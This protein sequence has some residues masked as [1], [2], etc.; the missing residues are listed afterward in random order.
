MTLEGTRAD[1]PAEGENRSL[2]LSCGHGAKAER[3]AEQAIAALLQTDTVVDAAK[4]TGISE[5]TLERWMKDRHFLAAYRE[6]RRAMVAQATDRLARVCCT[7]VDM[8][9]NVM[10]HASHD[11]ARV[12]AAKAI[13]DYAYKAIELENLTERLERL[14]EMLDRKEVLC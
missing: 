4:M 5:K 7:A 11:G 6:A 12:M 1:Y 2:A 14:E 3:K 9:A 8:L 13:L 10:K